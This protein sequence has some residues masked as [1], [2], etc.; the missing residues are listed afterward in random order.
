[1]EYPMVYHPWYAI[2][3]YSLKASV[4]T[5]KNA[6]DKWDIPSY[7][8]RKCCITILYHAIENTIGNT[9]IAA[10]CIFHELCC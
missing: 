7:L 9:I 6:S 8:T 10:G 3:W 5:K 1:M 4:Y 2:P